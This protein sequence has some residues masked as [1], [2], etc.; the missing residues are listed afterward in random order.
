MSQAKTIAEL[1]CPTPLPAKNKVLLGHGSGGT[2]SAQ[3]LRDVFL[4]ALSNPVLVQLNDQAVSRSVS[5]NTLVVEL[6][7]RGVSTGTSG[8]LVTVMA[9]PN[10]QAMATSMTSDPHW[11]DLRQGDSE[12]WYTPG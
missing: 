3:L 6:L 11:C 5:L 10:P 4:P 1:N 12:G 7:V 2:L 9:V 8:S